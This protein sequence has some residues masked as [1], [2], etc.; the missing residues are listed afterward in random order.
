MEKLQCTVDRFN[1]R[2]NGSRKL[3]E[4]LQKMED[5]TVA[6]DATALEQPQEVI[7]IDNHD[8]EEDDEVGAIARL[9]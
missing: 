5:E 2:P 9:V 8:E 3:I 6:V 1:R 4:H 7:E